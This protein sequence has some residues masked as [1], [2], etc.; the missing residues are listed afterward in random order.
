M[1]PFRYR[2][3]YKKELG[4]ILCIVAVS[5]ILSFT[6]FGGGGFRDLQKSRAELQERQERV[7]NMEAR[8]NRH[9]ENINT[10]SEDAI[11]SNDPEAL[12][13]LEEKARDHGYAREGEYI[14]R[15]PE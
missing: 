15:L 8:I 3:S 12:K 4:L 10:L 7:R 5:A 13:L 9:M 11:R 6:L 1:I 14:Q 2:R